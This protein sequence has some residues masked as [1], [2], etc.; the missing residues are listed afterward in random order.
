MRFD[1]SAVLFFAALVTGGIWWID[2]LIFAPRRKAKME[3]DHELKEADNAPQEQPIP[4]EPIIVDYARS[5]FPIIVIVLILR[6][7]IVEPF[8][9]PSASMM[10][11]LLIGDFILVNK[12][13]Y[14]LRL[15]I[16]NN[17]F[18][19]MELPKRGDVIVFRYPRDPSLDYIKRVIGLPGDRIG[20][21]DKAVYINGERMPQQEMGRYLGVGS[22]F[23]M[24][25]ASLRSEKLAGNENETVE[26]EILVMMGSQPTHCEY[27]VPPG[28]MTNC[29]YI[30]P[31]KNYF[32]M[33]DN[34]DRS[35]DSRFWG[36]VPQENLVGK[37]F[38]IWMNWDTANGGLNWGRIG[39]RIQ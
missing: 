5:F 8:R 34:R 9:I 4:P 7:F 27:N 6:A 14:G 3:L 29:E 30:V 19:E 12:F 33:G 22:A 15:P 26:H 1:F 35:N 20:Y 21:Y 38:F 10:P 36:M 17:K 37:A 31:P 18:V 25:G 2:A 32:V 23:D 39:N 16:L 28:H 11:T 13:A 24:T